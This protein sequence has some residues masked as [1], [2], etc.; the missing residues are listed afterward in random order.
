MGVGGE[1]NLNTRP[2]SEIIVPGHWKKLV[3]AP[4]KPNNERHL[5]AM[6]SKWIL[7]PF[8]F[9]FESNE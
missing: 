9:P 2:E 8:R 7:S 5:L 3:L 4:G 1:F 6:N